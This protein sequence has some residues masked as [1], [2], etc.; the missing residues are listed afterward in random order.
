MKLLGTLH[1]VGVIA[2][3]TSLFIIIARWLSKLKDTYLKSDIKK[4]LVFKDYL[5]TISHIYHSGG[6]GGDAY[7]H[8]RITWANMLTGKIVHKRVIEEELDFCFQHHNILVLKTD[9][10]YIAFNLATTKKL[11]DRDFLFDLEPS[12]K[13]EKISQIHFN[14]EELSFNIITLKG[15]QKN[16]AP[17]QWLPEIEQDTQHIQPSA[18]GFKKSTTD[19]FFYIAYQGEQ[20]PQSAGLLNAVKLAEDKDQLYFKHADTLDAYSLFFISAANAAGQI[21][22]SVTNQQLGIQHR[23]GSN[24]PAQVNFVFN[25]KNMLVLVVDAKRDLMLGLNTQTGVLIWKKRL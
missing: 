25:S 13:A 24:Q 5:I 23:M 17:Q 15:H 7:R 6:D 18:F 9:R 4:A 10:M 12:I 19:A 8:T 20:T 22:W 21:L 1:L 2:L 14:T 3:G 11:F 16:I